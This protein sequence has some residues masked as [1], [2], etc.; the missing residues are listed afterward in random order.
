M[1]TSGLFRGPRLGDYR[2]RDNNFNLIRF[3]AATLVIWT[4]AFGLL[5]RTSFEPVFRA[6][7]LGAG[8]LGVD[9]FFVLS[10]FLVSKSWDGKTLSQFAWARFTRIYP[11]LWLSI[12]A[13]V[14]VA[15]LFFAD[16]PA[17]RFLTSGP[18]IAYLAHNATMLPTIGSRMTLPHAIAYQGG[19]FNLALWTL[20]YELEMY[21]VLALMGVTVGLRAP[22]VG[23]L[24]ALGVV[25]VL[26]NKV[27]GAHLMSINRGRFL[28]LFFVGSF[29]Y[30]LRRHIPLRTWLAAILVCVIALT[31]ALTNRYAIRQAVLLAAL[32]YLLLWCGLVPRGIL[33]LWNRF[34]DYSYGMYIYGCPVQIALIATGTT[35]TSGANFLLAMLIAVLVA[36]ISWHLLEKRAL[37]LPLPAFLAFQGQRA[38]VP[39][40]EMGPA[41]V[42]EPI[43]IRLS[44]SDST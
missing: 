8:D 29:A 30:T 43:Q 23:A 44:E 5:D 38:P 1:Q 21:G 33:R 32:P 31:L 40:Q 16:E 18:T 39:A 26:L 17:T 28:Y 22:Y 36:A 20:P 41:R 11:G 15:A 2:G 14:L 13:T 7:H 12:L 37:R 19:K 4:H 6:L 3:V 34:G 9:I 35:T 42:E 25:G 10:G 24:A 27:G